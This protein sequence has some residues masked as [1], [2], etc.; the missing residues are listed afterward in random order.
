MTYQ[1]SPLRMN[2]AA[3]RS[4]RTDPPQASHV[5]SG[6]SEMR[7]RTSKT[8]PH[9]SHSY[10]YV[11]IAFEANG[12]GSGVS[13]KRWILLAALLLAA[14]SSGP[15]SFDLLRAQN[16]YERGVNYLNARPKQSTAALQAMQEAVR[17]D[18]KSVMYRDG[19]GVLLLDLG[20][21]DEAIEQFRKAVDLDEK[22]ANGWFHLGTAQ[23]VQGKW[24]EAVESYR[25]AI[26]LPTLTVPDLAQ[27]NLGFALYNLKRYREAEA[28]FRLA[29][30]LDPEMQAAYYHLGLLF[31]AEQRVNDAKAAFRR[32]QQLGP[33]TAFGL[34]ARDQLKALGEGG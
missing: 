26:S 18:P 33:D 6:S 5:V 1:P 2:G 25:V 3:E 28:A 8:R 31:T 13:S 27:Q 10:S 16:S 34:A 9:L 20:R 24:Q 29:L 11:G 7:W 4:R 17:I 15:S 23:A 32:A 22:F 21:P 30:S 12:G 19:L 14:C